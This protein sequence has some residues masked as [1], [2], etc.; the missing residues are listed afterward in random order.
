MLTEASSVFPVVLKLK[1]AGGDSPQS[2]THHYIQTFVGRIL[3]V[4]MGPGDCLFAVVCGLRIRPAI[5]L[6]ITLTI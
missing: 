2:V 6:S 5:M 3:T 1:G 4:W